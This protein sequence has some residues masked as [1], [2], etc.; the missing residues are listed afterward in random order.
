MS[1]WG[2]VLGGTFGYMLGGPLG[3][4]LGAALGHNFDKGLAQVSK[5]A[6]VIAR[7]S[8]GLFGVFCGDIFSYGT[9]CES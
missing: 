1:W 7:Q 2:K 5:R 3:A 4:V 9:C 6:T 8:F